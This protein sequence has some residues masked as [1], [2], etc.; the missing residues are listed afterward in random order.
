MEELT[1]TSQEDVIEVPKQDKYVIW[2]VEGG[3]GK[4]VAAT[5]LTRS[6]KERYP[7]RKFILVCSY[8]EIFLNNP[9]IYRVYSMSNMPYF[10]EDYIKGKDVLVFKQEPYFQTGHIT[11]QNHIIESWCEILDVPF[12]DQQPILFYNYMQSL[13]SNRWRRERPTLILQTCGGGFEENSDYNWSRD[14][15]FEIASNFVQRYSQDYHIL[16]V[17]R[18]NGYQLQNVE[19]IDYQLS[20]SDLFSILFNSQKRVLIDSSLQ[21]AA[22]AL[23]LSSNVFWIATSPVNFGYKIHNNIVAKEHPICNQLIGSYLFDY[24]FNNNAHECPYRSIEDMFDLE[25]IEKIT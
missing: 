6:I 7:D 11:R 10:Y 24:Q 15:P 18:K 5:A 19:R 1:D 14:L 17:T 23:Q 3:L 8:P 2:H 20:N 25:D 21:H 22:A 13:S 9:Y 4:N 16:H 12:T